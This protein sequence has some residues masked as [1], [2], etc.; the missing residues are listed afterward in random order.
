[1]ISA[2]ARMVDAGATNRTHPQDYEGVID[3]NTALVPTV[4]TSK[5]TSCKALRR[6]QARPRWPAL[7]M[8]TTFL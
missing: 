5:T 8:P 4:H 6:R 7:H 2:G 1:M 3:P